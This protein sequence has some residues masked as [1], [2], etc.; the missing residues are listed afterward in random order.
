MQKMIATST[1]NTWEV[2]GEVLYLTGNPAKIEGA[3]RN[4]YG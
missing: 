4:F 1:L 2:T 3:L